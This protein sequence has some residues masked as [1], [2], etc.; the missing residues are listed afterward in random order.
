M[1]LPGD[2][3]GGKSTQRSW[4]YVAIYSGKPFRVIRIV[5]GDPKHSASQ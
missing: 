2:E 3:P 1:H 5:E 4:S